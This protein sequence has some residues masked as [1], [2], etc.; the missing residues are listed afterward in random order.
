LSKQEILL[1]RGQVGSE[2]YWQQI[3]NYGPDYSGDFYQEKFILEARQALLYGKIRGIVDP[4]LPE[5][6]QQ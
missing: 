1:L 2:G 4:F 3:S 6:P 5:K